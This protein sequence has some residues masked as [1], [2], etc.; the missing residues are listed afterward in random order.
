MSKEVQTEKE[1]EVSIQ[2][3]KIG[4]WTRQPLSSL[5][6]VAFWTSFVGL[7]LCLGIAIA[8]TIGNGAPSRDIVIV[9]IVSLVVTVC[10]VSGLRWLQALS[11]L[12]GAYNLY[13]FFTEPFVVESLANPKGPNGGYGH[14]IGD[15]VVI[16][17][18]LLAF[19]ALI[20]M[21]PQNYRR[22]DRKMP[23]WYVSVVTCVVGLALGG[24]FIG[25]L[26]QPSA[27]VASA[28]VSYTNGVPTVHLTPGN[29]A[30]PVVTIAKGSKLLLVDDT[31][32]QHILVNG[33]WQQNT[34]ILKQEPGA[35]LVSNLSLSG[36]SVAIG[37][38]A[39]A[40][41]YHILC[42]LHLGMNLTINVQ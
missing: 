32:E 19:F 34:P 40:G 3:R 21:V 38:F 23:R 15:V 2:E 1:A 12:F 29:F 6:K 14:F 39:T 28:A 35:P 33:S 41:T 10:V 31:S 7:L 26:A 22:I 20:G 11:I 17:L 25:A 5:G 16:S 8:I 42:T 37:P 36:N 9:T 4:L 18:A 24:S 27:V 13:L 30:T